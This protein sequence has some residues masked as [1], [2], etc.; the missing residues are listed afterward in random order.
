MPDG[1]HASMLPERALRI[2]DPKL[3]APRIRPGA[4]LRSDLIERLRR[5]RGASVFVVSAPPGYGKR[6]LLTRWLA[7]DRRKHAWLTLDA[8]D[9]EMARL[10]TYLAL[11][12][13]GIHPL[14]GEVLEGI[15]PGK[16]N[17]VDHAVSTLVSAV[18]SIPTPFILVVNE[19]HALQDRTCLR[20]L[21]RL[22][23]VVPERSALVLSG[24]GVEVPLARL[25]ASGRVVDMG[26]FDLAMD[27]AQARTLL[28]NAGARVRRQ[29]VAELTRRTE[30]WPTGLYLAAMVMKDADGSVEAVRGDHWLIADYLSSELMPGLSRKTVAFLTRTSVLDRLSAPLC[31]AVLRAPGSADTLRSLARSGSFLVPLDEHREW[32]RYHGMVREF[33]RGELNRREPELEPLLFERAAVWSEANGMLES[34]VDYAHAAGDAEGVARLVG[35]VAK[36]TYTAGRSASLSRWF[37]W[38]EEDGSLERHSALAVQGAVI[39]ALLGQ[40]A[41]AERWADAAERALPGEADFAGSPFEAWLALLRALLCREGVERMKDDAEAA[42]RLLAVSSPWRA[43]AVLLSGI[44]SVLAGDPD[45]ADARLA[46]ATALA[47]HAGAKAPAM[48]ALAERALLAMGVSRW[49]TARDH[50]DR[51]RTISTTARADAYTTTA[52]LYAASARLALHQGTKVDA[53]SEVARALRLQPRL[54]YAM[55]HVAVQ[56]FLELASVSVALGDASAAGTLLRE[57]RQIMRRRPE[58]G[59]LPGFAEEIRERLQSVRSETPGVAALTSA[60]WRVLPLLSTHLSF[61][62]IGEQ[63]HVSPHTVKSQ[64]MSLYR[65][66]G[67]S[68]R[69]EAIGRARELSLLEA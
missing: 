65:K 17:S 21:E 46:D 36:S 2:I 45:D 20:L 26:A 30:G 49:A 12:F 54:T 63:L 56:T 68:S 41:E 4:V 34:A 9:N 28:E 39:Q 19:S 35:R 38:L 53:R 61:R 48:A 33:L 11:T 37:T 6:T 50:V 67:V 13:D 8:A 23:E 27:E 57:A 16:K 3:Q 24:R 66:L 60:E 32:Y 22:A 55:P 42:A 64:A 52:L 62:E 1:R 31:D 29:D 44:A 7:R 15:R 25:R 5:E 51:A 58:L 59:V 14:P 43:S 47:E 40:A 69:S 18:A 10:L